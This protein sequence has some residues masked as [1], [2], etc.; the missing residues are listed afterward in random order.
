MIPV[1]GNANVTD[2]SESRTD[3]NGPLSEAFKYNKSV[4]LHLS[5]GCFIV[6]S[7]DLATFSGWTDFAIVGK[8]S[9]L[10]TLTCADGVGLTFLSSTRIVF[11]GVRI[12]RCTRVQ[13]STSKNFTADTLTSK[14]FSFL[15]F[16]VGVYFLSCGDITMDSV[17]VSNMDG[18]GV[19][20]YNCNGTNTFTLSTFKLNYRDDDE[21]FR[22]GNVAIEFSFC[23]PGDMNCN[24]SAPPSFQVTQSVYTFHKCYFQYSSPDSYQY[25]G[26]IVPYPHGTEHVAFGKGGGLSV[27]FK[28]RSS[29]NSI[30][31]N[32]CTF[33]YNS[34]QWGGGLYTSFGDQS[35]DNKV[36]VAESQFNMNINHCQGNSRDW[37]QSGGGAQVDFI[38]YPADNEV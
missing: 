32:S 16:W 38:Y 5:E 12:I 7:N 29:G 25:N 28:G 8:G 24:D 18:V 14:H 22:N 20:M 15:Q 3:L 31:I 9:D 13:N 6:T 34:A 2:C 27:I 36:T 26:P 21:L 33:G 37:H 11:R 17:E 35:I 23:Q 10:S 30:N 4:Q 19:V 1:H